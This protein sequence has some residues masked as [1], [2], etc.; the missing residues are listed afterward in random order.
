[1]TLPIFLCHKVITSEYTNSGPK[2]INL[3]VIFMLNT[4]RNKHVTKL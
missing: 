4:I 2:I 3:I 1:M